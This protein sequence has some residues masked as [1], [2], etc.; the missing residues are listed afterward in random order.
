MQSRPERASCTRG[1]PYEATALPAGAAEFQWQAALTSVQV[2]VIADKA[3]VEAALHKLEAE[4]R[5]RAEEIR[6][7]E[8][9]AQG[10]M[11]KAAAAEQAQKRDLI[12]Q[13]RWAVASRLMGGHV[14]AVPSG[15]RG[16]ILNC[17]FE[18]VVSR[19]EVLEQT[20]MAA[21]AEQAYRQVVD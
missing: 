10:Q 7:A 6:K 4:N 8:A 13:L 2:Q 9:E 15:C 17:S 1:Q 21:G 18:G 11:A 19:A 20:S 5:Q 12:L 14:D 16:W 3:N